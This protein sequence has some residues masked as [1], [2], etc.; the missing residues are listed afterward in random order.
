MTYRLLRGPYAL[1][2]SAKQMSHLS[3]FLA[4]EIELTVKVPP[5][6]IPRLQNATVARPAE[7]VPAIS[8][9]H[10]NTSLERI[11]SY[12]PHRKIPR[13]VCNKL[14]ISKK[15]KKNPTVNVPTRYKVVINLY[16]K[17]SFLLGRIPTMAMNDF[18]RTLCNP[19]LAFMPRK[20]S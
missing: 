14:H 18:L 10:L 19:F 8:I 16:R 3:S 4:G 17:R 5:F 9:L 7:N 2:S 1:G 20:N 12:W 11:T 6:R 13:D 15:K